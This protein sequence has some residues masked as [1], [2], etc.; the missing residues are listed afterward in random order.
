[1]SKHDPRPVAES[2]ATD[3]SVVDLI[4]PDGAGVGGGGLV[5]VQVSFLSFP[6]LRDANFHR[7]RKK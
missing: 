6:Q 3:T 1:M 5:I 2:G 4:N 7:V